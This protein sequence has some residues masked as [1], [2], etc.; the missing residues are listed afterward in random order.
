[1]PP[2][3]SQSSSAEALCPLMIFKN[4]LRI[5]H[6][7]EDALLLFYIEACKSWIADFLGQAESALKF[8]SPLLKLSLLFLVTEIYEARTLASLSSEKRQSLEALLKSSTQRRL[9]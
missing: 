9:P 6:S 8:D 5:V 7:E 1:M 2:Q 3:E 4:H